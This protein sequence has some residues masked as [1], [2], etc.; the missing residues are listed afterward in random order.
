MMN[1]G[2]TLQRSLC[3]EPRKVLKPW[4]YYLVV[5]LVRG[6]FRDPDFISVFLGAHAGH[7]SLELLP[8]IA[9]SNFVPWIRQALYT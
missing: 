1:C 4:A 7:R 2:S 3:A 6:I 5:L 9:D 8:V